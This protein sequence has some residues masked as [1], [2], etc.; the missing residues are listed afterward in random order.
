MKVKFDVYSC[1][2]CALLFSTTASA[3]EKRE[4]TADLS[5]E[6][7]AVSRGYQEEL[8][9]MKLEHKKDQVT[10]SV[11]ETREHDC[12]EIKNSVLSG[13]E[14]TFKLGFE[15][16]DHFKYVI[17]VVLTYSSENKKQK[18][19]GKGIV[20]EEHLN[21]D[22]SNTLR[23]KHVFDNLSFIERTSNDKCK[24]LRLKHPTWNLYEFGIE[25]LAELGIIKLNG[26]KTEL[27]AQS[28]VENMYD[29]GYLWNCVG[30]YGAQIEPLPEGWEYSRSLWNEYLYLLGY[31][32]NPAENQKFTEMVKAYHQGYT[33]AYTD[34]GF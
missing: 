16:G 13:N 33:Q 7:W 15:E 21:A 18:L 19:I 34:R 23:E 1:V 27:T 17:D 4:T 32:A 3:D 9:Y 5:G 24:E 29:I 12:L 2:L 26:S 6:W 31:P 28:T 22:G 11:C 25:K 30:Y 8:S 10:G 14:L 20:Y